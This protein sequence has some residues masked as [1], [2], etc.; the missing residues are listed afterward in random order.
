M[1]FR[2]TSRSFQD[3]EVLPEQF[4]CDG[5]NTPPPLAFD[6]PPA[7]TRSFALI[8][9]DPDAPKGV[10]THWL[11]YNIPVGGPELRVD[12][13]LMMR[14]DFGSA[15]Y[16]GACP[17]HGHGQHRYFFTVYALGVPALTVAGDTRANLEEALRAH[18]LGTARLMGR[19]ERKPKGGA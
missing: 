10:F 9:D 16:G 8:M 11:A 5:A 15:G 1:A 13:G 12:E 2:I 6:D 18:T 7:G 17:P 3:G 19:Y 14:N 4:T